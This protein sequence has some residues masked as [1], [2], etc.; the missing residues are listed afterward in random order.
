MSAEHQPFSPA[1]QRLLAWL[2]DRIDYERV[3]PDGN[4]PFRL[5]RM[6]S[7]LDLV[8]SPQK[9]IPAVHL[10]GTKG[11]GSTAAFLESI[12]RDSGLRTGLFTSPHISRVEERMRINGKLPSEEQI[13]SLANRLQSCL[14]ADQAGPDESPPT[15]FEIIT[16]L[17]WMLFAE[18]QVDVVVLETGLGGRLDCT[19]VCQPLVTLITTIGLDHTHIL[20]NTLDRIAF[21]KAGII[22]NGI[23]VIHGP[24]APIARQVIADR[25]T[26]LGCQRFELGRDLQCTIRRQMQP[27]SSDAA[28]LEF[29]LVTPTTSYT[30]LHI[31]LLGNHQARNASLAVMAA[32]LLQQADHFPG[33]TAQTIAHGLAATLWPLRFEQVGTQPEIVLDAA[34]NP[35]SLAAVAATL[36]QSVW[37][38]AARTLVF[39]ASSDKDA[40][41]MLRQI[42]PH[43]GN[44][45]LTRFRTNPR[46][47]PPTE[48]QATLAKTSPDLLADRKTFITDTPQEALQL[49]QSMTPPAGVITVTGS[50]FLAAEARELMAAST[51]KLQSFAR[52]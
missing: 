17:A 31:P 35:D 46:S 47:I 2:M 10:A 4:S 30:D 15:F 40:A 12:L 13:V 1:Y 32:Q 50:A 39:A 9:T 42:L 19:N 23:P 21:E 43:C 49:A 25:A 11:K 36:S 28:G 5:E 7:L 14:A 16:L 29:N 27:G 26:E 6:Q 52:S 18:E 45:I 20:G 24:V 33:I 8:G 48:L 41:A 34:H 37:D 3:R 51:G 22:K 44:L 38:Q